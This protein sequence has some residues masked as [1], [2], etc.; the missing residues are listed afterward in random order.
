[1]PSAIVALKKEREG[2]ERKAQAIA[3]RL[4][5]INKAIVLLERRPPLTNQ[6]HA[7]DDLVDWVGLQQI[8]SEAF[9]FKV[10]TRWMEQQ[11]YDNQFPIPVTM[12]DGYARFSTE[13]VRGWIANQL[14]SE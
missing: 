3:E 4:A 6:K 10:T 13:A 11:V 12:V 14:E 1:M 7:D 2:L 8:L 5:A 9:P